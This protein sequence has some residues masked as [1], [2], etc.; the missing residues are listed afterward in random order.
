MHKVL[1]LV[2]VGA[3]FVSNALSFEKV[4]QTNGF[5]VVLESQKNF[6]SGKNDFTIQVKSNNKALKVENLS[7]RFIMHEM[8]GMPKMVEKAEITPHDSI[9]K[10]VV[11]FPHGGTWQIRVGFSSDKKDYQAKGSIDF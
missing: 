8:P 7:V 2:F 1:A 4:L 5:E 9:Y 3:L 10:G 6:V 11:Y